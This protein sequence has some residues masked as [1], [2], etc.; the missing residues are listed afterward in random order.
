MGFGGGN[1]A[2][3]PWSCRLDLVADPTTPSV[4]LFHSGWVLTIAHRQRF[5]KMMRSRDVGGE[6]CIEK[7]GRCLGPGR[8]PESDA[9]FPLVGQPNLRGFDPLPHRVVPSL[10]VSRVEAGGQPLRELQ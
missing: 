9:D 7:A 5:V 8:M 4:T 10:L 6:D 2:L 1:L 3:R